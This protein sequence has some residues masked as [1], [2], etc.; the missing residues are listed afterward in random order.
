M[1]WLSTTEHSVA[2]ANDMMFAFPDTN[3]FD[4]L[5]HDETRVARVQSAVANGCVELVMAPEI[6]AEAG[7]RNTESGD[8]AAKERLRC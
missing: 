5:L 8:S 7:P 3:I 6:E 4:W 2:T 1:P